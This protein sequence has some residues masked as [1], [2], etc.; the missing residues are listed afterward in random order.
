MS[1]SPDPMAARCCACQAHRVT[2]ERV[3]RLGLAGAAGFTFIL[4]LAQGYVSASS[5]DY[6]FSLCELHARD[7][8]S[9][10]EHLA[11]MHAL[12]GRIADTFSAP[13]S[14]ARMAVGGTR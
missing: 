9:M 12:L 11:E 5:S 10:R 8:E 3:E 4:G 14:G 13:P 2:A 1:Q 6:P 7:F